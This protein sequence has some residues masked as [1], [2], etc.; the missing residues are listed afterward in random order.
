MAD[1]I[2]SSS[3]IA[4]SSSPPSPPPANVSSSSSSLSSSLPTL[5]S[6]T[7]RSLRL[8]D[9]W[10]Y[11]SYQPTLPCANK[12]LQQKWDSIRNAAATVDTAPPKKYS[13]LVNQKRKMRTKI[14]LAAKL[15]AENKNLLRRIKRQITSAPMAGLL[16]TPGIKSP[17][18]PV[19]TGS[20]CS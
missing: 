10:A 13:H 7:S 12:L 15:H 16:P 4:I 11:R 3:A 20:Y 6:P 9:P 18:I 5:G 14:E 17:K 8:K 19:L 2:T 1:I